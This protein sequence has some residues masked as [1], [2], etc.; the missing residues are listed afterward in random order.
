[1]SHICAVLI[2]E[3]H[4]Y[5]V[6]QSVLLAASSVMASSVGSSSLCCCD[7][8]CQ[9]FFNKEGQGLPQ[10]VCCGWVEV[11]TLILVLLLNH[12]TETCIA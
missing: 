2:W 6:G 8:H 5:S 12:L 11:Q 4:V 10:R 9:L 7:F 1:M 3:E